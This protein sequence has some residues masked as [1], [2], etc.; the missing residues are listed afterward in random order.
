LKGL[1]GA[2][3]VALLTVAAAGSLLAQGAEEKPDQVGNITLNEQTYQ[4]LI[5]AAKAQGKDDLAAALQDPAKRKEAAIKMIGQLRERRGGQGGPEAQQPGG[6]GMPGQPGPPGDGQRDPRQ[7]M[8]RMG[9][10][11]G[12]MAPPAITTTE[13]YLFIVRGDTVFQLDID[14]LEIIKQARLPQPEGMRGPG[15][16]GGPP[17]GG[18]GRP[19]QPEGQKQQ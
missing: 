4:K 15:G 14:T 18:F 9:A 7:W 3:V 16:P 1:V 11:M 12:M 13:K 2:S 8:Q 5:E 10:G 17:P 6:P 19:Q